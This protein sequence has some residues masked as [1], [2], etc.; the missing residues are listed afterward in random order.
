M[1]SILDVFKAKLLKMHALYCKYKLLPCYKVLQCYVSLC[2]HLILLVHV[3]RGD[4][5]VSFELTLVKIA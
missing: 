4:N 5:K 1:A 3:K 2:K